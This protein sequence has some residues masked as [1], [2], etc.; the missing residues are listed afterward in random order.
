MIYSDGRIDLYCEPPLFENICRLF[1]SLPEIN[2]FVPSKKQFLD[3][4]LC[5]LLKINW[6][7]NKCSK[8]KKV[9]VLLGKDDKNLLKN[10]EKWPI[11]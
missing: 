3:T 4:D 8:I 5:E 9:G 10:I 6:F 2:I 1:V 7:I 11:I